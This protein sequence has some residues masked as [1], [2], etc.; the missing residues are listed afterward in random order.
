MWIQVICFGKAIYRLNVYRGNP[1][2]G[3][4]LHQQNNDKRI[5]A[6]DDKGSVKGRF[7]WFHQRA[8]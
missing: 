8:V 2:D 7:E 3:Y 1:R 6:N 5:K 4:Y